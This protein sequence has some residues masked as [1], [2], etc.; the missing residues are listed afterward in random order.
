MWVSVFVLFPW[1]HFVWRLQ[2][3]DAV[4]KVLYGST[5]SLP[6]AVPD[7]DRF[8]KV[9]VVIPV[10]KKYPEIHETSRQGSPQVFLTR[11]PPY[12]TATPLGARTKG[13]AR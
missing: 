11:H 6:A 3:Q 8:P 10:L 1:Q 4:R 9:I 5:I 13:G 7:A 2:G 12:G